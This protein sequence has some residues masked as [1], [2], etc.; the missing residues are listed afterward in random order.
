MIISDAIAAQPEDRV[1]PGGLTYGAPS[2]RPRSS[3]SIDAMEAEGVVENAARIG[4][5]CSGRGCALQERHPSWRRCLGVF[6][7]LDLSLDRE[8][9]LSLSPPRSWA[10]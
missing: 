8:T 2:R 9:R 4:R 6:W 5:T 1:F 10:P 3:A 7:A